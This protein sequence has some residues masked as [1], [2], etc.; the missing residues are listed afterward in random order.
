MAGDPRQ[1]PLGG[2]AGPHRRRAPWGAHPLRRARAGLLRQ[3]RLRP[4][5]PLLRQLQVPGQDLLPGRRPR[6]RR[7]RGHPLPLRHLQRPQAPKL[8][9]PEAQVRRR[10]RRQAVERDGHVHRLRGRVDGRGDGAAR[11]AGHR[12]VVA[13]HRHP[14]R[15]G[16]RRDG[17]PDAAERH[18]RAVP[19]PRR[20]GGD[21]VRGAVHGQ[22]RGVPFLPVLGAG[23]GARRG[24][25]AGGGVPRQGRAGERDG[26]RPQ[27]GQRAG[28][29]QRL[30]HRGDG[31]ER[32]AGAGAGRRRPQV[33]EGAGAGVR[34]LLRGAARREPQVPGAVRAGARRAGAARR[35]RAR[36]RAQGARRVLQRGRVP[37]GGAPGGGRAGSRRR[38]HAPG[39]A[40]GVGPQGVAVPQG[41]HG[42]LVLPQPGGA[43]APA[44]RLPWLRRGVPAPGK[45]P[46]AGEQVGGFPPRR[47][48]GAARLVPG[49]EQGNGQDGG[50]TVGAAAA[51]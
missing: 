11:P 6:R 26:H 34:V 48:H 22:G 16:G 19:G 29:A 51:P 2:P 39:R 38:V 8:Q 21:G 46:R 31:R 24:A 50:R 18:G 44:R 25:Q 5:L 12:R 23:A 15:V 36:R 14:A 4:L 27:P 1:R 9:E 7:L 37:G 13:R 32:V 20:E 47:A 10:R 17:Q 42:H 30:R 41:D 45:R 43:P 28:D 40:S 33:Q 3:L 49:G 35:Q